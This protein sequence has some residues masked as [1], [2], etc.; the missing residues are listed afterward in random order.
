MC[1]D[2][3]TRKSVTFGN[4]GSLWFILM[5]TLVT[6]SQSFICCTNTCFQQPVLVT[7][8]PVRV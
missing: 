5:P 8:Q 2:D 7:V 3:R 6:A 4:T 1:S